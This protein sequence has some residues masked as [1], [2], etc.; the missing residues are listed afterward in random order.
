MATRTNAPKPRVV[1]EDDEMRNG[2]AAHVATGLPDVEQDARDAAS[3]ARHMSAATSAPSPQH[4]DG[5]ADDV[6]ASAGLS[7]PADGQAANAVKP[8]ARRSFAQ[9]MRDLRG[10]VSQTFPG[11]EYAVLFGF[12]GF[13]AAI[14]I[15]IIGFW[16]TLFIALMIVVGVAFGQQLDGD[17][18]IVNAIR[19]L[20]RDNRS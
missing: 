7:E 19:G 6:V 2:G 18:K 14:L 4:G 17:P 10:W 15:F 8:A 3:G 1:S 16:R 11:H 9:A 12:L 20:V 5:G 13:V